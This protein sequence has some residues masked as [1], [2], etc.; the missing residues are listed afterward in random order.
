MWIWVLA[1]QHIVYSTEVVGLT[2]YACL[3]I[4]VNEYR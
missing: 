3:V 1:N 4:K 2:L